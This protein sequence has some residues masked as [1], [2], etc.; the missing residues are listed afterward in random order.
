MRTTS[1]APYA[2][3]AARDLVAGEVDARHRVADP[4]VAVDVA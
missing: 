2:D 1:A 3:E 4:E